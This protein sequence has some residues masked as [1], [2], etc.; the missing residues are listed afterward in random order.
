MT[1]LPAIDPITAQPEAA[2]ALAKAKTAFG[3]AVP[4]L[5]RVMANSPAALHAYLDLTQ[6]L[7][8][9]LLASEVSERIALLVA[10]QNGCAYCLS[11]HTYIAEHA[12]G[13]SD[14]EI[15]AARQGDSADS[16][17]R[18]LLRLASA[19]NRGRGEVPEGVV[20]ATRAAGVSDAEIT[21]VVAHVAANAFTNYLA[22]AARVDIDFPRVTPRGSAA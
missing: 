20:E 5:T 16:H 2:A 6:A 13:L 4:N 9:G 3:G 17:I 7:G 10:E 19:V 15:A 12:L 11:A 18:S 8:A 21:E 1:A 22:K 14:A